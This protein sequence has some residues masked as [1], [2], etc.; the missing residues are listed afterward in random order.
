[1][2]TKKKARVNLEKKRNLFFLLG[3]TIT[4]GF[5]LMAFEWRT[6][7]QQLMEFSANWVLEET[8]LLPIIRPPEP[9][10]PIIKKAKATVFEIIEP[11][12]EEIEPDDFDLFDT[13]ETD[14]GIPEPVIEDE[15]DGSL[16]V[17]WVLVENKP[18][19]KGGEEA[20]M[21]FL[22]EKTIYPEISK[23]NNMEGTV[24]VKFV[25]GK[26]GAV[27]DA[28]VLR[29]V[30]S[31]IDKEALRVVN[32]LP[33]WSPGSQRGKTVNVRFIL[34]FKFKLYE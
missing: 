27:K 28:E 25:V 21:I 6:D 26:D 3:L 33:K 10:K 24:Y 15:D 13:E 5:T 29:G 20:L 23:S 32:L 19:F 18:Q 12:D 22:A 1:M 7:N 17:D 34:P 14:L 31:H 8:E 30:D 11:E 9:P 2:K 4:L 16:A